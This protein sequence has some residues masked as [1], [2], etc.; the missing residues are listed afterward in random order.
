M[1]SVIPEAFNVSMAFF[2][3][4]R[5]SG[6]SNFYSKILIPS[7]KRIV[8]SRKAEEGLM[9]AL[10]KLLLISIATQNIGLRLSQEN[11][12]FTSGI[13]QNMRNSF[14]ALENFDLDSAIDGKT[15]C[16]FLF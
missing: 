4:C 13:D 5:S 10:V 8:L 14:C 15:F 12:K 9:S 7:K 6:S 16:L 2:Y 1:L 3:P 11:D